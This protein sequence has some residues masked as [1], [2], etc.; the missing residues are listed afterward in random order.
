MQASSSLKHHSLFSLDAFHLA[1]CRPPAQPCRGTELDSGD[2]GAG[3][4]SHLS[5]HRQGEALS[6][7]EKLGFG[8]TEANQSKVA[9]GT[10]SSEEI[11]EGLQI[12]P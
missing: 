1:C 9:L 10:E 7:I 3:T 5:A 4:K 6:T 8:F 12:F 11:P 2:G